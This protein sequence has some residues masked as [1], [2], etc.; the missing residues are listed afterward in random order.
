MKR[1]SGLLMTTVLAFARAHAD[2]TLILGRIVDQGIIE[3]VDIPCSPESICLDSWTRWK[4]VVGETLHGP[5]I[6][7]AIAA[8]RVQHGLFVPQYRKKFKVFVLEPIQDEE[9]RRLLG[10]EYYLKDMSVT[11]ETF[12]LS[13]NSEVGISEE[14]KLTSP[15]MPGQYC[16][17]LPDNE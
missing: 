14:S 17:G 10:A 5:R 16:F 11:H 13:S 1:Q 7:G 2:E 4:I 6:K 8:A 15:N 12:C 9:K 3:D